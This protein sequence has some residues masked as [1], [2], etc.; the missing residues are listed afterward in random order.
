MTVAAQLALAASVAT[1]TLDGVAIITLLALID[2]VVPTTLEATL[3][4]AT[5]ADLEVP[6]VTGFIARI[7]RRVVVTPDAITARRQLTVVAARVGFVGVPVIA[8]FHASLGLPVAATRRTAIVEAGVRLDRVAVVAGLIAS[9][10]RLTVGAPD[11]IAAARLRAIG[12]AGV[13][14]LLV[15]VIAGF[16]A[17]VA[18]L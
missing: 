8:G 13:S 17:V 15:A 10:P 2:L 4:V 14:F 9:L 1:V 18:N 5:V 3:H 12:T 6:V 11:P 7:I 16:V